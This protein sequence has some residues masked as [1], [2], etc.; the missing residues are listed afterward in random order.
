MVILGSPHFSIDEF[1]RL[2]PLVAGQRVHE[3][4]EVPD[5][6]G[7]LHE[8]HGGEGGRARAD[9]RLRRRDHARHLH[10]RLADAAARDPDADDQLAEVRVLR[11]EPARTRASRSGASPTASA[12]RSTGASSATNRCGRRHDRRG[13]PIVAG[14]AE[15][16]ALV[17]DEPLSFWGGYDFKT[18]EI[19]DR[20]HPLAGVRAAGRVLAL[21]FSR[22]SSTTTAVLL[23]AVR[24]GHG[25]GRDPD[26]RGGRVFRAGVDRRR[27]DVRQVVPGRRP[28]AGRLRRARD[29]RPARGRAV[30][31]R[32][33]SVR[34]EG[35]KEPAGFLGSL[36]RSRA[37][38]LA[39]TAHGQARCA[40]QADRPREPLRRVRRR[41]PSVR[42]GRGRR[43]VRCGGGRARAA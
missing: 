40:R 8:G 28:R 33:K 17:T 19:I 32:A 10:S 20:H 1:R 21:P 38:P 23:E 34:H 27:G 3:R 35:T 18:G 9:R 26:D 12:R 6:V 31:C 41:T 42:P 13:A 43:G 15:G 4:R 14:S 30:G 37:H 7:P 39:S 36:V 11:A 25:A 22:G 5:H 2:A 24:A 29:R 16:E